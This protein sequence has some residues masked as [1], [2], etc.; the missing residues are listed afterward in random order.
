MQSPLSDMYMYCKW[1]LIYVDDHK[2]HYNRQN[3][4]LSQVHRCH[5]H[6][7]ISTVLL[8]SP[9]SNFLFLPAMEG[10]LTMISWGRVKEGGV[11]DTSAG[12]EALDMFLM[13]FIALAAEFLPSLRGSCILLVSTRSS[14]T[15]SSNLLLSDKVIINI[16]LIIIANLI[17]A[18]S[19]SQFK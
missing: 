1:T 10:L 7:F 2:S 9:P 12:D 14:L 13:A 18:T 17:Y 3:S 16:Q 11:I 8:T 4:L 5:C 15:H 6:N 19:F